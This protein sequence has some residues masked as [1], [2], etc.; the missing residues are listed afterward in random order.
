MFG[1]DKESLDHVRDVLHSHGDVVLSRWSK[2]S[3]EKR[4]KLLQAAAPVWCSPPPP[5]LSSRL[6]VWGTKRVV[7]PV[8]PWFDAV[9]FAQDRMK[10][11]SLLHVRCEYDP[12]QWAA[13]D[14]RSTRRGGALPR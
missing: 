6:D 3:Q 1:N 7:N 4:A 10:L 2:F 14:T 13:F 8:V 11:L 12:S 9:S 5:E